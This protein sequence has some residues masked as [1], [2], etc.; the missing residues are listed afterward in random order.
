MP[1]PGLEKF[2]AGGHVVN[3]ELRVGGEEWNKMSL[4][5]KAEAASCQALKPCCKGVIL[6]ICTVGS[7]S[8][9]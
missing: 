6:I 5:R 1:I 8:R 2:E 7:H 9:F 4:E 3:R